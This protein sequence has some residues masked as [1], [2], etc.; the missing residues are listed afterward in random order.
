MA[1]AITIHFRNPELTLKC[2]ESL[3]IDGWAPV[4]VWD[5]SDDGGTSLQKLH[6][7]Y[8]ADARVSLYTAPRTWGLAKE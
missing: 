5:N 1:A 3:L 8:G 4:L 6:D 7:Y 2:I